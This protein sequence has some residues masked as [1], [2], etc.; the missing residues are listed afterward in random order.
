MAT[1]DDRRPRGANVID[2]E[3]VLA[4]QGSCALPG[5]FWIWFENRAYILLS[6][7]SVFMGLAFCKRSSSY[8]M[9]KDGE[10]GDVGNALG[11]LL[12][13][14][15][16]SL[17]E[18]VLGKGDGDNAVD[19]VEEVDPRA[20][21][22]QKTSHVESDFGVMVILELVEYVAREGMT[23]VIKQGTSFLDGDLMPKHLRHLVVVRILPSVGSGK[24]QVARHANA[25]FATHQPV[26]AYRTETREK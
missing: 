11:Y 16:T 5:T 20:F 4:V 2:D 14:V 12:A 24:M 7:P 17:F 15:V 13:L 8:K 19:V 26:S 9:G 1:R 23:L 22:T 10:M 3:E 21:L 18:A 25:F 6:L